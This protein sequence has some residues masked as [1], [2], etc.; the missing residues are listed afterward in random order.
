VIEELKI[1]EAKNKQNLEWLR[2]YIKEKL[3]FRA[4]EN[5]PQQDQNISDESFSIPLA[6]SSSDGGIKKSRVCGSIF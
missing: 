6:N 3:H 2:D 4:L 5:K 1:K